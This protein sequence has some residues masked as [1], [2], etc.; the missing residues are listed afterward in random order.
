MNL[1][2]KATTITTATAYDNGKLHSVKGGSVADFDVV[3]GSAATRVNAEGLIED[4]SILS[5]E[6]VTNGDFATD[7]DWIKS[8]Q[9]TISNG[10]SNILSTD[11][12]FQFVQQ[13]GYTSTQG[14][15]VKFT[16]D[17]IDIQSGQLKVS[18]TGGAVNTNIPNSVGL[19]TLYIPN[20]GTVGQLGVS[21]VGGITDITIDNISVVEV[22][23]ATNIPR[24]DYTDGTASILL[25]PQS[26]NLVPYSDDFTQWS[27]SSSTLTNGLTSPSG[28]NSAYSVLSGVGASDRLSFITTLTAVNTQHAISAFV[29]QVDGFNTAYLRWGHSELANNIATFAFDTEVLTDV[30]GNSTDLFVENY[31]NGWYRIGFTFTTGATI[32]NQQLQI[33]RGANV[34]AAYWGIQIEALPY[35]TSYIPTNGAIATRLEDKVTGA[36]DATTFNS[37]EG[38][39]Y[40]EG[41]AL[42]DD[43]DIKLLEINNGGP[44]DR[45]FIFYRNGTIRAGVTVG[46][47][48]Q[49]SFNIPENVTEFNKVA[50]KYKEN[51]F[52]FWINGVEVATDT[53]GIAPSEGTLN[54]LQ[55]SNSSNAIPLYG[56]V[57]SLITFNTALTDAELEC[58]T[59]I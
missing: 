1:L 13:N 52:A 50:L 45:V 54:N 24:I 29:K 27:N 21:R 20:D 12:S 49:C 22:I 19:H 14:K 9:T 32:T 55:L 51:D 34:S 33:N 18:F 57:K 37:T 47:V 16:I 40:F 2:E 11:G 46:G 28:D 56:K 43:N 36:G 3:R 53:S 10:S 31:G 44:T 30:S 6:L 26:T 5:G 7:S 23:D 38:V 25:E 15:N 35:A 8:S 17:I 41:S 39:L 58:L 59:T 42:D 4:I 48:A